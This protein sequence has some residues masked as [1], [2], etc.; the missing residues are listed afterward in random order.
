MFR[1]HWFGKTATQ[2]CKNSGCF[3]SKDVWLIYAMNVLLVIN[4]FTD[5]EVGCLCSQL[6]VY[7]MAVLPEGT[8]VVAFAGIQ[9]ELLVL[10]VL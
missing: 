7:R 4:I 8:L 6:Q 9:Q 1:S 5:K 10:Q 2:A 3:G